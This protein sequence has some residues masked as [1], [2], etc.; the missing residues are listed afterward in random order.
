MLPQQ[1]RAGVID[2]TF[3]F[4]GNEFAVVQYPNQTWENAQTDVIATLG[5]NWHLAVITSQAIEDSVTANLVS[6]APTFTYFQAAY[7]LG[8]HQSP[9][10]ETQPDVGWTWVTGDPWSYTDWNAGEPNDFGGLEQ[11]LSMWV[12]NNGAGN[13]GAVGKWNDLGDF[14]ADLRVVEGYIAEQSAPV[15][16]PEP[17]AFWLLGSG[18]AG[19]IWLKRKHFR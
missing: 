5:P 17:S 7:W 12:T 15:P 3:S 4:G 14:A 9:L 8:G 13:Y 6:L 18:L 2:G 1:S 16:S 19:L 11:Y 10:T